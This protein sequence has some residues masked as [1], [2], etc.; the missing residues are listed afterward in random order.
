MKALPIS[1]YRTD[2]LG[3]C[4]NGGITSRYKELLLICE[5]GFVEV[6]ENDPP[7]NLV[8]IV[9]RYFGGNEHKHIEPYAS[10]ESGSVGWMSG[11]NIAYTCDS[12]FREM[13]E[14]PLQVHD[15]QETQKQYDRTF[16]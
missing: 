6:D 13:S 1:V 11:G 5:D 16:D 3:D 15:R 12:R 9:T 8:K 7:E 4:T 2:R 10:V 14:Y